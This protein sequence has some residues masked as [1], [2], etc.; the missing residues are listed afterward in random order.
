MP[1]ASRKS[2]SV[3]AAAPPAPA[4]S[5]NKN[6]PAPPPDAPS[7]KKKAPSTTTPAAEA[8][9]DPPPAGKAPAAEA[10]PK[11][12]SPGLL[13]LSDLAKKRPFK[14]E[15]GDG[16]K[17]MGSKSSA[18]SKDK[19]PPAPPQKTRPPSGTRPSSSSAPS[20]APSSSSS[21]AGPSARGTV[22][23]RRLALMK[24]RGVQPGPAALASALRDAGSGG[25]V[26]TSPQA[27]DK[28]GGASSGSNPNSAK[29]SAP[30][31]STA[32]APAPAAAAPKRGVKRPASE[33]PEVQIVETTKRPTAAAAA[34][35]AP[36][37]AKKKPR[38]AFEARTA[39][40]HNPASHNQRQAQSAGE[41]GR[42]AGAPG[43]RSGE[44]EAT[45]VHPYR[46]H[47]I[48]DKAHQLSF[49][50]HQAAQ[51][52]AY[53]D[54]A[55]R[56]AAQHQQGQA[57]QGMAGAAQQLGMWYPGGHPHAGQGTYAF[58]TGGAGVHAGGR[59]GHPSQGASPGVGAAGAGGV[60]GR[61]PVARHGQSG[62]GT[63]GTALSTSQHT[64]GSAHSGSAS[65]S[66]LANT[67][68]DHLARRASNASNSNDGLNVA[69]PVGEEGRARS[70]STGGGERGWGGNPPGYDQ[71]RA[72][73]AF[74][75]MLM[76]T[77]RACI[78]ASADVPGGVFVRGLLNSKLLRGAA[79]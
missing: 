72:D 29:S 68:P 30:T 33:S 67:S 26:T 60:T 76:D 78:G 4:K 12:I 17:S 44:G 1:T 40:A 20:A 32:D 7:K 46:Y 34:L 39:A 18:S 53:R 6:K 49:A 58:G 8:L 61:N 56:Y 21:A 2:T 63:G 19:N 77:S 41:T 31:A 11:K 48:S 16:D 66:A 3:P 64:T 45:G 42:E 24:E 22:L 47:M 74:C 13:L 15:G 65:G 28:S 73:P 38:A 25:P 79:E 54:A 52:E 27:V 35:N 37:S 71:F 50:A 62:G 36:A 14:P 75:S 51:A 59:G 57:A 23:L 55:A 5:D 9:N 43:K 10:P 69:A 70:T